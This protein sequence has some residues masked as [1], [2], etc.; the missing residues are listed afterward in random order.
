MIIALSKKLKEMNASDIPY[1]E[2]HLTISDTGSEFQISYIKKGE[3]YPLS[4]WFDN[5]EVETAIEYLDILMNLFRSV[6]PPPPK[7]YHIDTL[8]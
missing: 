7:A 3:S 1:E 2:L 8:V 4:R 6:N 5:E